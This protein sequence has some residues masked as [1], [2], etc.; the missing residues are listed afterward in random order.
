M[1]HPYSLHP[2]AICEQ[3]VLYIISPDLIIP[4]RDEHLFSADLRSL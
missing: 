4:V 2:R 3:S 1:Y